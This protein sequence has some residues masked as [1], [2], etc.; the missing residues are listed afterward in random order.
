MGAAAR[1]DAGA[2]PGTAFEPRPDLRWTTGI[3]HVRPNHI[4]M[5]G[6]DINELM[7]RVPFAHALYLLWVGELPAPAVGRLIDAI[8]VCSMDHGSTPPS[9]LTARTVASTG[10]PLGSAIAAGVLALSKYHGAAVEDCMRMIHA[11][12]ERTRAGTSRGDAAAAVL[13]DLRARG[14][15]ASGLGHRLHTTD[16]RTAHLFELARDVP[17]TGEHIAALEAVQTALAADRGKALPINVDGAIAAVLCEID[18]PVTLANA[19]FIIARV[20]GITA[21]AHEEQRTQKPM[22]RI[23]PADVVYD[24]PGDRSLRE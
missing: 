14:E 23:S 7:G 6:Y 22:R 8:L 18:F 13:A 2:S 12:V 9:V 10:A 24:G 3:S 19:L 17:V 20:A 5:R 4:A 11:V 15:R 16:P 1:T 21:Q